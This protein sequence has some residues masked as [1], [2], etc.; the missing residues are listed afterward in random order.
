MPHWNRLSWQD[1]RVVLPRHFWPLPLPDSGGIADIPQPPLRAKA[2]PNQPYSI[3][4]AHRQKAD[5]GRL[6]YGQYRT[7]W[8]GPGS[9]GHT[10]RRQ[11]LR[12]YSAWTNWKLTR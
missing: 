8:L 1:D 12:F 10:T 6:R 4:A 3:T 9:G 11:N 2:A 5:L 7:R